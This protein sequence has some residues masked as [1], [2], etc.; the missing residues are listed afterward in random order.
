M[1]RVAPLA[2]VLAVSFPGSAAAAAAAAKP[3][4]PRLLGLHVTNGS[5][6]FRGDGPLLATVSP[7]H[8]G[9]RDAAHVLFRLS[10]P[11]R[12][13]LAVVQTDTAKSDPEEASTAIVQRFPPRHFGR[14]PGVLVWTPKRGIAPRTY[15]LR[16]TVT[17]A[18]GRRVYG[19]GAP[20]A[21]P[22][23]PVVR[24]QGI[25]A[26]FLKPSY[27]PGESAAVTVATDATTLTFQ[28]FA[29]GGG[30][31]PSIRDL[32]TSGQ[33][34]T[35]AARVDWRA[36]RDAPASIQFVRP[37]DWPSGLY[38]LRVSAA[39]GRVGY[40]PLIVRPRLLGLHRVAV[41]LATQ[42]WQAYNFAD[43]NGDGWGDSW[44][45]SGR[46]RSVDLTRA[47]LDFGLPFRFHDWDLT[48][49]T[50]L[51][52]TG[53]QVD[54]LSDEDVDAIPSGD[55][56]AHHYDLVVFPGHEE[57]VT[58]HELDVVT[59]FRN[60]GGNLAYLAA[61]N[62]FWEVRVA[63]PL[64]T[65]VRLWRDAGHPEAA[66]VGGQYV[67]S[68][69]GAV[70]MP[71]VVTGA[72]AAPWLFAGTGLQNGST[73]GRYG[74]EIDAAGPA[75]PAG[76]IVLARIPDLLGPGKS[77]EMTYYETPAGAKVFDAGAINFAASA[78]QQPVSTMLA[79]LWTRLSQ[80]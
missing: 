61:N 63:P 36:H 1:R 21:R 10:A 72:E 9:F 5:T 18:G 54:F 4:P 28:V 32:R 44:Y 76:T 79:N 8:D 71:F 67:G 37:G 6:P 74:I 3:T 73:F 23:G 58:Q 31:F 59:R 68:N 13:S 22:G 66:L 39:D 30:A 24:I 80:P 53:K 65:K 77:A 56:L 75:S 42:T 60:L 40:A 33:A 50:W 45:V 51:Q 69:R 70:Q 52:Q 46:N 29:Y 19:V 35:A 16:L 25:D 41:V 43:A 27:A 78:T 55:E 34:M 38:F 20:G 2:L 12:V 47:F 11:A 14:G 15:V 48:F 64:M 49:L 17:G 62:M 26:G 57:Y 7:N